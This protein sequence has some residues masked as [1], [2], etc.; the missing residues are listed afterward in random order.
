[1]MDRTG[2]GVKPWLMMAVLAGAVVGAPRVQAQGLALDPPRV[3][4][5]QESSQFGVLV[6]MRGEFTGAA[7]PGASLEAPDIWHGDS[8]SVVAGGFHLFR[9]NLG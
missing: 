3:G 4:E 6:G 1:M 7:S 5:T 9:T 2:N 8:Y